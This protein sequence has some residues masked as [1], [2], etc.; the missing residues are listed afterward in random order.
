[1]PECYE[2]TRLDPTDVSANSSFIDWAAQPSPFKHYPD[3]LPCI[4]PDTIPLLD[5]VRRARTI[6]DTQDF[7]STPYHRLSTPSAGNLHPLELYVQVRG[8]AN[9]PSGIYHLDARRDLL[10]QLCEVGAGLERFAGLEHRF[11]GVLIFIS[12]VPYRSEWK[13]GH[14]AWRY[15]WMDAG[16]QIGTLQAS[17]AA[18]GETLSSLSIADPKG[19][20][21]F[22]GFDGQE[23]AAAMLSCGMATDKT[24]R[25]PTAPL[26]RV[27]P[28]DYCQSDGTVPSWLEKRS[29]TLRLE[30]PQLFPPVPV[31]LQLARRSAR[32]FCAQTLGKSNIEY[33]LHI[34]EQMRTGINAYAVI[35]NDEAQQGV[36]RG[37]VRLND[38]DLRMDV[39]A[40]LVGQRFIA[41]A[42]LVMVLTSP[43]YDAVLQTEAALFAH[44]LSLEVAQRGIGYT[45]IGAFYDEAM[46]R[47]LHT[48][49]Y[50]LYVGAFG[51]EER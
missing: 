34:L 20:E 40:L 46:R 51:I 44:M 35:L 49:E 39:V 30:A 24:V 36:W 1:M 18:V 22:M 12:L 8:V 26:M 11:Q 48:E 4:A 38:D 23:F 21:T 33:I 10:V 47:F 43:Q 6:T 9:V 50:V 15:C 41:D 42:S 32:A 31:P 7:D 3:F 25:K 16:H 17:F 28:T 45:G 19:L 2:A 13:Y 14:R 29:E 5:A 27:M 37:D